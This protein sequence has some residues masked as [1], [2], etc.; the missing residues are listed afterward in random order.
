MN[1]QMQ[2]GSFTFT[3]SDPQYI[4]D[5]IN[6]ARKVHGEPPLTMDDI[7]VKMEEGPLT[8]KGLRGR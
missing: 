2:S 3:I 5:L 6:E 7:A 4:L 1:E 8:T